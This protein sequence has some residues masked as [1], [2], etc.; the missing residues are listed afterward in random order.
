LGIETDYLPARDLDAL[1][2]QLPEVTFV[3]AEELFNRARMIKTPREMELLHRLSRIS[4]SSIAD[5]LAAV[6]AGSSEMDIAAAL[7]RGIY[8]RGAQDFR[9]M[10]I[11]TGERSQ[12]PNVGPTDRTLEAGD[13]CRVEIFSMI[14]GYHAGV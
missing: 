9:F 7:T 4:D 13:I 2:R 10:I 5:A 8:S 3:P 12:L 6:A 11:A 14:D 1:R